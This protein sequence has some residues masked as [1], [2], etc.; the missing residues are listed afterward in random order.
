VGAFYVK[1]EGDKFDYKKMDELWD[2]AIATPV[3]EERE[4]IYREL[5][6]MTSDTATMIPVFHKVQPYVWNPEVSIPMNYP[7]YPQVY[8][9]SWAK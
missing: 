8:E 5:T 9:W 7:N 3:V 4:K 1:Y 6:D 2:A